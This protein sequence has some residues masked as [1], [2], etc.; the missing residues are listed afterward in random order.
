MLFLQLSVLLFAVVLCKGCNTPTPND[1]GDVCD[2]NATGEDVVNAVISLIESTNIFDC[3]HFFMRRLAYVQTNDGRNMKKSSYGIW[4]LKERHI[5]RII[6]ST[7][8]HLRY[9]GQ[10]IE[11]IFHINVSIIDT[12]QLQKPLVCGVMTRFYFLV[13]NVTENK[14]IP[15][16]ISEQAN[17]W[18]HKKFNKRNQD[19]Q[20]FIERVTEL[21]EHEGNI[22]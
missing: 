20:Y 7:H 2:E 16:T 19:Q 22:H 13:L 18:Y 21:E 5:L 3:D 14:T 9:V 1:S 6:N 4:A 15:M 17:L 8:P 11:E 12:L 10:L